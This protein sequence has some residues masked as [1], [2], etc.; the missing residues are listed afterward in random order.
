MTTLP[1][2]SPQG[3]F[4]TNVPLHSRPL[5]TYMFC[6]QIGHG[7]Y[8][9]VYSA[10]HPQTGSLCAIKCYNQNEESQEEGRREIRNL[11]LLTG[12]PHTVQYLGHFPEMREQGPTI[13]EELVESGD[14]S[15][16]YHQ[17][18]LQD[19]I[20][21]AKQAL[22]A[23]AYFHARNL[24]YCDLKLENTLWKTNK[25]IK[26]ADFGSMR[27]LT[28]KPTRCLVTPH[29]RAIEVFLGG[30][31]TTSIDMY[32]FGTFLFGLIT[33]KQ[34]F[35]IPNYDDNKF[36]YRRCMVQLLCAQFGYPSKEQLTSLRFANNYFTFSEKGE[37]Q[38]R[39]EKQIKF[40]PW[41]TL[42]QEGCRARG[43]DSFTSRCF[44]HLISRCLRHQERITAVDALKHRLFRYEMSFSI[45]SNLLPFPPLTLTLYKKDIQKTRLLQV[46]LADAAA[47]RCLHLS[48]YSSVECILAINSGLITFY[49]KEITI[50]PHSNLSIASDQEYNIHVIMLKRHSLN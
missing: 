29:N 20:R 26:F 33:Q 18:T 10:I 17:F 24:I 21:T 4:V 32:S 37:P 48:G 46:R 31:Y 28:D 5:P 19:I 34:L 11:G 44:T 9:K 50:K 14:L 3:K 43:F 35:E 36:H 40:T 42:L 45:V 38:L 13:I 39:F 8:A 30:P 23:L 2:S 6:Q 1:L 47:L 27:C 7:A 41:K 22:E 49:E 16:H 15:R 12:A 25:Y